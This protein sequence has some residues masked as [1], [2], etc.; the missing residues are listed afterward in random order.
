MKNNMKNKETFLNFRCVMQMSL[1][2]KNRFNY[3]NDLTNFL[4]IRKFHSLL[5]GDVSK[6]SLIFSKHARFKLLLAY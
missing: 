5:N 1:C 3:L 4:F 2:L 6:H